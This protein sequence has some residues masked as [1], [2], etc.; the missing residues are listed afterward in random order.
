MRNL[1][2]LAN[3]NVS[4]AKAG[5]PCGQRE[6]ARRVTAVERMKTAH[7]ASLAELDTLF[8]SLQHRAFKGEL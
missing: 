7:R 1:D 5:T 2:P 4:P 3:A 6:F 8:A